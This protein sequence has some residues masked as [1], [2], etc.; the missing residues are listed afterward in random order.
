MHS[1]KKMRTVN[2]R[3]FWKTKEKFWKTM[4]HFCHS[5]LWARSSLTFRQLWSVDSLWNAYVTWQ[6]HTDK[7]ACLNQ[8]VSLFPY[9]P[10]KVFYRSSKHWTLPCPNINFA[11]NSEKSYL[12]RRSSFIFNVQLFLTEGLRCY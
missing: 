12:T 11:Q 4:G 10:C 2:K 7:V 6:E 9:F 8:L 3:H 1:L 5:L